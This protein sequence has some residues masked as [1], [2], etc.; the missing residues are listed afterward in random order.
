MSINTKHLSAERR[1][2]VDQKHAIE[3]LFTSFGGYLECANI[4]SDSEFCRLPVALAHQEIRRLI[5]VFNINNPNLS[6]EE[7]LGLN[8]S[9]T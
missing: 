3:H 5:G 1:R 6:E 8:A 4:M 9:P 7:I 2:L